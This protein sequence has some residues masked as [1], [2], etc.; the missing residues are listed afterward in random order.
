M[1]VLRKIFTSYLLGSG[2]GLEEIILTLFLL[3][4]VRSCLKTFKKFTYATAL[5]PWKINGFSVSYS[6]PNVQEINSFHDMT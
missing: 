1:K 6:F 5:Y 3:L 4:F 2:S